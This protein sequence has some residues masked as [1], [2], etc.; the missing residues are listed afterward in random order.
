MANTRKLVP[1]RNKKPAGPSFIVPPKMDRKTQRATQELINAQ[2]EELRGKKHHIPHLHRW[3]FQ[4]FPLAWLAAALAG[5]ATHAAHAY[6]LAV[7]AAGLAAVITVALTRHRGKFTRSYLQGMALWA[8][9]WAVA[10]TLL[11][12]G[13]WGGTWEL[14]WAVPSAFWI[15]RHRWRGP[16]PEDVHDTSAEDIWRELAEKQKWSAWLGPPVQIPS[17]R[18]WPIICKGSQ[19]HI[20]AITNKPDEIAAAYDATITTAYAEPSD[21]SRA[22]GWL[23]LL[24][25]STLDD[26][27]PW[28]GGTIDPATGLAVIGRFP[29]GGNVHEAWFTRGVGGGTRHAFYA[30]IDG[31]G[32]TGALD[33]GIAISVASGLVATVILDPQM[34]QALPAWQEVLPYACGTDECMAYLRGLYGAMMDRSEYLAQVQWIHPRTGRRRK[35][36]GFFDPDIMII[37]PDGEPRPLGLPYIEIV[38]DEAPILLATR[39]APQLVLDICK[40][41]RKVGFRVKMAAQVPSIAEMGKGELR[42]ILNGGTGVLLRTGDKVSGG[43]MNIAARS[44]ELPLLFP[45][46]KPTRGLGYA[47]T[48]ENR[49]AVTMRLDWMEEERLYDFAESCRPRQ[50][51]GVVAERLRRSV[52]LDAQRVASVQAQGATEASQQLMV[53]AALHKPMRKG[54]LIVAAETLKPSEVAIALAQ[55]EKDGRVRVRDDMVEPV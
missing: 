15:E 4:L 34:G 39:G 47:R 49:P 51:D 43:M 48:V 29:E 16:P 17:G 30:G 45:N 19:T 53:L 3:R 31:S 20:G 24:R 5:L 36:M 22:R 9:A 37:G 11:G 6:L 33:L 54:E 12:P 23:T 38:M 10:F 8:S 21:A 32:K 26:A 35:G 13:W 44:Y 52:E 7:L 50:P 41:A 55:L 2:L 25:G 14:G 40:L 28:D 27:R 42:S 1:R 18:R 46:G